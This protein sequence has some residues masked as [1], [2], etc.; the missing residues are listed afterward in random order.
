[1]KWKNGQDVQSPFPVPGP[2]GSADIIFGV[3]DGK[4]FFIFDNSHDL[5]TNKEI[6]SLITN[7]N[8]QILDRQ[9]P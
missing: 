8:Q 6:N 9:M 5:T 7:Y 3:N 2:V 4:W 1:L